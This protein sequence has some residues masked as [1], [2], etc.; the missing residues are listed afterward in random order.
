M[1]QPQKIKR[2]EEISEILS[3]AKSIFMTDFTGLS[4]E[5]ISKLRRQ[6]KEQDVTYLVVKNTLARI[7]AKQSGFEN[8]IPYLSGPTGLALS[9]KDPVS[10]VRII[11]DFQKETE[12]PTIKAAI[13]E[14][15]LLDQQ[16]AEQLRD[17]PSR[18]VLLGQVLAGIN[19]PLA[20]FAGTLHT[21]LSKL[22]RTV[23]ALC[24]KKEE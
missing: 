22:V 17:I 1:P 21:L 14:G 24:Q 5:Q 19:S 7:S 10:P 3:Q 11:S 9:F 2:V 4:V 23:D 15:E 20:G 12:K 6:F 16:A 8:M 18:E 13:L